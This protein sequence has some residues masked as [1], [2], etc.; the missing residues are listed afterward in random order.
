MEILTVILA[1]PFLLFLPGYWLTR[2]AF[3][4]YDIIEKTTFS[5]ALSMLVVSLALFAV[6]RTAGRLTP[7]NTIITV[8][9]VNLGTLSLFLLQKFRSHNHHNS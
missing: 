5:V 4:H 3:P 2:M 7:L 9:A 6:E 8:T 1:I